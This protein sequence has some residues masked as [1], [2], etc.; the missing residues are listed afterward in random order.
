MKQR[1][2]N[3]LLAVAKISVAF[4][5]SVPQSTSRIQ[6]YFQHYTSATLQP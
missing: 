5:A 3:R 1:Q 6:S 2:M 4:Q